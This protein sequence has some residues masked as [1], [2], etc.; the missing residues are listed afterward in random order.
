MDAI[1]RT[2]R[3]LILIAIIIGFA[4]AYGWIYLRAV[5]Q[6]PAFLDDVDGPAYGD[7]GHFYHAA[8]AMRAHDDIYGAWKHGYIYPPLLAFLLMPLT[9]LP[10]ETA[11]HIFIVANIGLS[12][13][14]T[15][16]ATGD[17]ARR[18]G[19]TP[20]PLLILAAALMATVLM[21]DIIRFE[22][23]MGQTNVLMFASF[24]LGLVW[25]DRRPWLAG[26]ALGFGF[27]IKYL[28]L[29]MLPYLLARRRW[30][31]AGGFMLGAVGFALVPA[32]WSGWDKNLHQLGTALAG[33]LNLVGV[34]TGAPDAAHLES[35]S[36]PLSVSVTSMFARVVGDG[37]P[38]PA[39]LA[40]AT[41]T[42]LIAVAVFAVIVRRSGIPIFRWPKAAGHDTPPY[43]GV[44]LL[45][46]LGL[47]VFV[48]AFG[49]QTNTRHF[50]LVL[51]VMLVAALLI[52]NSPGGASRWPLIAGVAV[53]VMALNPPR[54]SGVPNS[55]VSWWR[56]HAGPALCLLAMYGTVLWTGLR[57]CQACSSAYEAQSRQ[58]S[59]MSLSS[60]I[61]YE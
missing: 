29:A 37:E 26:L 23:R 14:L 13:G 61:D 55:M 38:T 34:V 32:L 22:I 31:A 19:I 24:V 42:A 41:A 49:P 10:A 7:F 17:A 2:R 56:A 43:A 36:A 27:N 30:K 33:L 45:E 8:V 46:W 18:L 35:I 40:A 20:Q 15:L 1:E 25:L 53:L 60:Q 44:V 5:S 12:I 48:L 28:S 47:L 51:L 54:W 3:C 39:A 59:R 16:L 52:L 57:S 58:H 50:Y 21:L 4:A 11:A 6:I 9:S